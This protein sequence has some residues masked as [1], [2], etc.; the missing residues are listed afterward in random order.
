MSARRKQPP[1][2]A[3]TVSAT[4]TTIKSTMDIQTPN[5]SIFAHPLLPTQTEAILLSLYPATLILGSLFT[6]LS[7][8]LSN[9]TYSPT[10]Q[11]YQPAAFAPSYF[12]QKR[13]IFNVYFVKLGWLWTTFALLV[14]LFTHPAHGRPLSLAPTAQRLRALARW[15]AATGLWYLTTQWC[16]G[17]ALIDRSFV[18]SGGACALRAADKRGDIEISKIKSASSAVQCKIAGGTWSGGIDI[19]GHVFLLVL[20]SALLWLEVLPVVLRARGLREDRTVRDDDGTVIHAVPEGQAEREKAEV[21]VS[22]WGVKFVVGVVALMWWML[23]MTAAFFHTWS[24][25][26]MGLIVAFTGVWAIYFLPRGVPAVRQI[27]GMPGL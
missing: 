1:R 5:D 16:F 3:K 19:S 25:K 6:T 9:S 8:P 15:T 20:A 13:N 24:E 10:H 26:L 21:E 11:S 14:F 12:A 23:L 17:P 27:L 18:L 22:G 4:E 7:P 2:N